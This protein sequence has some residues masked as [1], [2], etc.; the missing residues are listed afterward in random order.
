[1]EQRSLADAKLLASMAALATETIV[2]V[3]P[4]ALARLL[5]LAGYAGID[6]HRAMLADKRKAVHVPGPNLH[7]LVVEARAL[8]PRLRR[9]ATRSRGALR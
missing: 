9:R 2:I 7:E 5:A 1:M 6:V 4:L 8:A 3:E